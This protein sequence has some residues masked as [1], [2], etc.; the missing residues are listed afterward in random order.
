MK[1]SEDVSESLEALPSIVGHHIFSQPSTSLNIDY[2]STSMITPNLSVDSANARQSIFYVDLPNDL[3]SQGCESIDTCSDISDLGKAVN[4]DNISD[5]S[6]MSDIHAIDS[7]GKSE[8]ELFPSTSPMDTRSL[9]SLRI[10]L[11]H[12][13]SN[14][15]QKCI[16][17]MPL[18]NFCALWT[19]LLEIIDQKNDDIQNACKYF[20]T[21]IKLHKN[22]FKC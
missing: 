15:S 21:L 14:F 3:M 6:Q 18:T 20:V 8:K 7:G 9:N 5:F 2:P 10:F 17:D 1:F 19:S 13:D 11:D 16:P 22:I 12:P 4:I